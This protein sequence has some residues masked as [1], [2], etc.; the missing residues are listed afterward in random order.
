[1]SKIAL[2]TGA[3]GQDGAYLSRYLVD[4]GYKVFGAYRRAASTN[5]WRLGELKLLDE[6]NFSLIELDITDPVSCI[7]AIKVAKPSEIYNLAAQSFVGASFKEPL[8]TSYASGIAVLNLLEAIRLSDKSIKFYQAG[9]SEMFG[10]VQTIP[11]NESTPF[12]PRSPYGVAKLYGHFMSINYRESYDIFAACGILFNH[13]SPLRGLEFVT[14]K[15]TNSA[16]KIALGK[17]DCLELGNLEA[18]RDWGFAKDY[19]EG[20][21]AMLQAPKADTFV[22]A[23][24][25][26]TTVRDFVKMSFEALDIALVFEGEGVNEVARDK[27]TGKVVVKVNPEFFRPAEVDLLIGDASKAKEQLNWSAK[28]NLNELCAMM[29]KADL[30]RVKNGFEF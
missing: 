21:H 3:T 26:T 22:L 16:A 24:G 12:Y 9:T 18:K 23:S 10:K 6:A 25:I 2:V 30:E 8:H 17:L 28:T 4:L 20:M 7:N 14:R 5:L 1:M 29:V 11:Q 27:K 19:V 13:E 15:I